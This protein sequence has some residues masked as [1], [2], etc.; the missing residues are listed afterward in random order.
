MARASALTNAERAPGFGVRGMRERVEML[1]GV[2]A[3][4]EPEH[5]WRVAVVIPLKQRE[6][7][8]ASTRV[9]QQA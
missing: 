3:G 7:A 1:D 8:E 5:G 2:R 6:Q 4:P 9:A